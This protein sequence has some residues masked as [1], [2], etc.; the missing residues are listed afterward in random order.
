[1]PFFEQGEYSSVYFS[2]EILNTRNVKKII[3]VSDRAAVVSFMIG[4]DGYTISLGV[5]PN[6]LHGDNIIA[7]PPPGNSLIIMYDD[8][9][10]RVDVVWEF[11]YC[12]HLLSA[13]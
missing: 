11:K 5:F 9:N 13:H 3:K 8:L 1:M 2:E 4:L 12:F 10:W 7:V 6:Y